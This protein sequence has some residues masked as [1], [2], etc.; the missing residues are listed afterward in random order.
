VSPGTL[1]LPQGRVQVTAGSRFTR[2]TRFMN[3]EIAALLEEQYAKQHPSLPGGPFTDAFIRDADGSWLCRR[4][5]HFLGPNGPATAT[6]GVAYRRG[7]LLN[8][9]DIAAFLDEWAQT[10]EPPVNIQLL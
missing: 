6:P 7:K 4:P 1:T 3:V 5:A 10:G 9:Y 8:G 2:G